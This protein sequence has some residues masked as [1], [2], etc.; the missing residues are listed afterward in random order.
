MSLFK[1]SAPVGAGKTYAISALCAGDYLNRCVIY[2]AP[3]IVL[4]EQT[5][6]TMTEH[7]L[8]PTMIHSGQVI[9]GTKTS[10]TERLVKEILTSPAGTKIICSHTAL[11]ALLSDSA[12]QQSLF[13]RWTLVIDEETEIVTRHDFKAI[14]AEHFREFLAPIES[15][16]HVLSVKHG[17]KGRMQD[18]MR[19]ITNDDTLET[20]K[21]KTIM[22]KILSPIYKVHGWMYERSM[23]V[24]SVLDPHSLTVFKEVVLIAAHFE[25]TL[26]SLVWKNYFKLSL[27]QFQLPM[28]HDSHAEGYRMT[29]RYMLPKGTPASKTRLA[30]HKVAEQIASHINAE[31]SGKPFIY[32]CNATL[33]D[34][35][36]G[37]SNPNPIAAILSTSTKGESVPVKSHGLNTYQHHTRVACLGVTQPGN[38]V[39]KHVSELAGTSYDEVRSIYRLA[40]VYQTLGRCAIRVKG[41]TD[42][43]EV[44]VLDSIAAEQIAELF[45]GATILGQLG[46]V[47]GTG[48][49]A[50]VATRPPEMSVGQWSTERRWL[51]R[52]AQYGLAGALSPAKQARFDKYHPYMQA[53]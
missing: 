16:N 10:Q 50:P 7:G 32:N 8:N 1:L 43:I 25:E 5:F 47:T 21:F 6:E 3:T 2:A 38:D 35:K 23:A 29:I 49:P 48:Q 39:I 46:D 28:Y 53:A 41:N 27:D 14:N 4:L 52:N 20:P 24:V 37:K 15:D 40:T 17:H 45:V 19:G 30:K 42:P 9:F 44:I 11:F 33:P 13:S 22:S 51:N 36:E 26:T 34:H 12:T 18:L 31:W